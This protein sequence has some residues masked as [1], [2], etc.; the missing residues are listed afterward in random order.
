[1]GATGDS[2]DAEELFL[3]ESSPEIAIPRLPRVENI[4]PPPLFAISAH[5]SQAP[6]PSGANDAAPGAMLVRNG[7]V[8]LEVRAVDPAI[9]ALREV[10][11]QFGGEIGNISLESRE[12]YSRAE[13]ELLVP[14]GHFDVA[15]AAL[16][17]IGK[18]EAVGVTTTDM[19]EV[20]V[21]YNV[22]LAN[23]RRLEQRLTEL[24]ATHTG[25]LDE[26]LAVER[27]LARVRSEIESHEGR[28]RYI[29]ARVAMSTIVITLHE[30]RPIMDSG[31]GG[32]LLRASFRGAWRNFV[33]MVAGT[34]ELSGV[35]LPLGLVL[36]FSITGVRRWRRGRHR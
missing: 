29:E 8:R 32:G 26:V 24:L 12:R 33:G 36:G 18:V 10:A 16:D 28:I 35:F 4:P 17:S 22:R 13:L 30:P 20:Y 7:Q 25:K 3:E 1:M 23:A 15:L 19:G 9:A 5:E 27:E 6:A 11:R 21:D 2:R 14:R 31:R 34:I